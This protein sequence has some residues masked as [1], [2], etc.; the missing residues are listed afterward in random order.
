MT[1]IWPA[2]QATEVT[3]SF[4]KPGGASRW[5]T[6]LVHER[7]PAGTFFHPL[8]TSLAGMLCSAGLIL[9]QV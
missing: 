6:D 8:G 3:A 1:V 2:L 9:P 7:Q 5:H 4:R